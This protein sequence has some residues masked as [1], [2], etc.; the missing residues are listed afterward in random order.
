MGAVAQQLG[1]PPQA[2]SV[3]LPGASAFG[4]RLI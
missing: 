2:L 4:A 1:W 3:S